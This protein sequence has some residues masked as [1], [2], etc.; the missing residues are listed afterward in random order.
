MMSTVH[1]IEKLKKMP[2]DSDEF[3][4]ELA[5]EFNKVSEPIFKLYMQFS[6]NKLTPGDKLGGKSKDIETSIS[7]LKNT[8]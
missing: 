1:G 4:R 8:V 2:S 7:D 3:K 5:V 6:S